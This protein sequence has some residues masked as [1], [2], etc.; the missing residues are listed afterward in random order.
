MMNEIIVKYREGAKDKSD[1][2]ELVEPIV[3]RLSDG[4]EIQ[5][6]AGYVTD[7]ASVPPMLWSICPPIGKYNR[8]A[9]IHDYLYDRQY[10]SGVLGEAEAR[11]F[12]DLQFLR[13]ANNSNPTGCIRHYIM[14]K[15]VRWFGKTAWQKAK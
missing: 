5:V 13:I 9:L 2:W 4:T 15:F 7:F 10:Q 11:K 8:A 1:W 12:A 6:P 3:E 14:Y